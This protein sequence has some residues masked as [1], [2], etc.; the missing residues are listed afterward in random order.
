MDFLPFRVLTGPSS[1]Q[2]WSFSYYFDDS[3]NFREYPHVLSLSPWTLLHISEVLQHRG[4]NV[5]EPVSNIFKALEVG[6]VCGLDARCLRLV[7]LALHTANALLLME[8][9]RLLRAEPLT[10]RIRALSTLVCYFWWV[11]PLNMEVIGWLSAQGYALALLQALLS[12]IALERAIRIAKTDGERPPRL[13]TLPLLLVASVALYVSAC[14]T[15]PPVVTLTVVHL[16]RLAL[17]IS[18]PAAPAA[19]SARTS[20]FLYLL[21]PASLVAS[22]AAMLALIFHSNADNVAAYKQPRSPAGLFMALVKAAHTVSGFAAR[23]LYPVDLRVHYLVPDV[24]LG[25]CPGLACAQMALLSPEGASILLSCCVLCLAA[26]GMLCTGRLVAFGVLAWA[27]LWAPAAGIFPHGWTALGGDR[28]AYMPNAYLSAALVAGLEMLVG[29]PGGLEE[30]E[31]KD[32]RKC[33]WRWVPLRLVV[34]VCLSMPYVGL[35][36]GLSAAGLS[37]W[38]SDLPLLND[39]V[40]KVAPR[41]L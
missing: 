17:E 16:L 24:F 10:W 6:E 3:Y 14:L 1:G 5:Y 22:A 19:C 8:W 25:H 32:R 15:K 4:I 9:L 35:L 39:C 18:S 30:E 38:R 7:T 26:A 29:R 31:T 21:F 36:G 20:R 41:V 37:K 27:C 28:Y 13:R 33:A 40:A 34:L 11:H 23:T 12:S 2:E